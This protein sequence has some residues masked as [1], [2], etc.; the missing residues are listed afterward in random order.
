MVKCK[1]NDRDQSCTF[2][3][4]E[5][6]QRIID[7]QKNETI[8]NTFA[9]IITNAIN[10]NALGDVQKLESVVLLGGGSHMIFIQDA[11][12]K[13]L[14]AK[15]LGRKIQLYTITQTNGKNYDAIYQD[16]DTITTAN[17]LAYAAALYGKSSEEEKER[18]SM[19]FTP[20]ASYRPLV[21]SSPFTYVLAANHPEDNET[22]Y[23]MMP[24]NFSTGD[25]Y[26]LYPGLWNLKCEADFSEGVLCVVKRNS[27]DI[28][29]EQVI[30][31]EIS[32]DATRQDDDCID[33][34]VVFVGPK[35]I[36][37]GVYAVGVRY[38]GTM[39]E[40]SDNNRLQLYLYKSQGEV[41]GKPC[42]PKSDATPYIA[43]GDRSELR[44]SYKTDLKFYDFCKAAIKCEKNPT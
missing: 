30:I 13:A 14:E 10:E 31:N 28:Q 2:F 17:F 24:K 37:P 29:H 43:E 27:G 16:D 4:C 9:N 32:L 25:I 7:E 8:D 1:K 23:Y 36:E 20:I 15:S 44:A 22:I 34:E 21:S 33:K 3:N 26:Y 11:L 39:E 19:L 40:A 6:V 35:H 12:K 42:D 41:D 5:E 38:I 18:S